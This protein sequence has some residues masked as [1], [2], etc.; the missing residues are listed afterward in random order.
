MKKPLPIN[1]NDAENVILRQE[2]ERIEN[3]P[4]KMLDLIDMIF[5][6]EPSKY[7]PS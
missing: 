1:I 2:A 7:P 5:G 3:N 4:A 6:L